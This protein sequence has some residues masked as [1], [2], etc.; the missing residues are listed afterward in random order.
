MNMSYIRGLGRSWMKITIQITSFQLLSSECELL[1]Q[2]GISSMLYSKE[3]IT[4][5]RFSIYCPA[6]I[7]N[8]S[9]LQAISVKILSLQLIFCH[10]GEFNVCD[11]LIFLTQA[12]KSHDHHLT[13]WGFWPIWRWSS[14]PSFLLQLLLMESP[15]LISAHSLTWWKLLWR[16]SSW[17]TLLLLPAC[18]RL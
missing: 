17:S 11:W 2:I 5:W 1:A 18:Q 3:F 7:K 10:F 6:C 4:H 14:S 9:L 12:F 15:I 13:K 8:A 16:S